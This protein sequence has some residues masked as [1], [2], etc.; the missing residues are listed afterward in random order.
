VPTGMANIR[1]STTSDQNNIKYHAKDLFNLD[2]M[3]IYSQPTI[4]VGSTCVDSTN[5]RSRTIEKCASVLSK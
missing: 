4:S 3:T 5:H 1:N 2:C